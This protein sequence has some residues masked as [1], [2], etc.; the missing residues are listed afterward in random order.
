MPLV[1]QPLR[2]IRGELVPLEHRDAQHVLLQVLDEELA[3]GIPLG[4]EGVLDGLGDVA[5]GAHGHLAVGVALSWGDGSK[6]KRAG[7]C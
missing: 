1:G 3:V 5:L 4:I 2:T 6:Q 7:L